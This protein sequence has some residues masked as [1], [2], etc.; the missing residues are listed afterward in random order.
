MVALRRIVRLLRLADR[1][2]ETWASVSAA[3]LYVLR[4]LAPAS[5][6]EVAPRMLFEDEVRRSRCHAGR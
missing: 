5:S 6:D 3:Q 1:D 2:A 4:S